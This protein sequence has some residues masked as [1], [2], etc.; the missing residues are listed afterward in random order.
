MNSLP[1]RRAARNMR[2]TRP[3][4]QPRRSRCRDRGVAAFV[5]ALLARHTRGLT[6]LFGPERIMRRQRAYAATAQHFHQG[7]TTQVA[8]RFDLRLSPTT[9]MRVQSAPFQS[10]TASDGDAGP[11]PRPV[12]H[13]K[14]LQ[15]IVARER[16]VQT[17]AAMPDVLRAAL[18]LAPAPVPLSRARPVEMVVRRQRTA[19]DDTTRSRPAAPRPEQD[20]WLVPPVAVRAAAGAASSM[21]SA[22]ELGRV[23][24]HVMRAIDRRFVAQRE[25]RGRI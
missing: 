24:D 14:L 8:L 23:T 9:R 1:F 3:W 10:W 4:R 5:A 25:R 18:A 17:T 16:R 2:V 11:A 21:L 19:A 13:L 15:R 12:A 6:T 20:P 22:T 7:D